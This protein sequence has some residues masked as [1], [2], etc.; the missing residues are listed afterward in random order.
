MNVQLWDPNKT[1]KTVAVGTPVYSDALKVIN[2]DGYFSLQYYFTAVVAGGTAAFDVESSNDGVNFVA[3]N[4]Q[5]STGQAAS[6]WA[7]KE[8]IMVPCK[9]ARIKVT[10]STQNITNLNAWFYGVERV[11]A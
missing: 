6:T 10:A 1:V 2:T 11:S 4:T 5:I 3:C 9:Y 7:L 8:V